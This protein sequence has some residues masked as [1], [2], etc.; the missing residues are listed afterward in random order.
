[1]KTKTAPHTFDSDEHY[2]QMLA[3]YGHGLQLMFECASCNSYLFVE[4]SAWQIA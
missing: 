4:W 3:R 2:V 1:M